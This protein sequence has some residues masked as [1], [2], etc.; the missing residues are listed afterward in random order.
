MKL[1]AQT[2]TDPF[3][4]LQYSSALPLSICF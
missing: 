4:Q 3:Q 1:E 2:F